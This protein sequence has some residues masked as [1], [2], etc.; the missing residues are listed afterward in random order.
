MTES[1]DALAAPP[2]TPSLWSRSKPR[3]W[4]PRWPAA[5]WA[6]RAARFCCA[7]LYRARGPRGCRG[8]GSDSEGGFCRPAAI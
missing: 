5:G 6:W 7:V 3:R 1:A 4:W 2:Q 8:G